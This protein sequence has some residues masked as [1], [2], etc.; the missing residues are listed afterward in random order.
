[1]LFRLRCAYK[2]NTLIELVFCLNKFLASCSSPAHKITIPFDMSKKYIHKD[3]I[4]LFVREQAV[5]KSTLHYFIDGS[6]H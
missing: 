3:I 4:D 1:M 5:S 6:Q 2:N